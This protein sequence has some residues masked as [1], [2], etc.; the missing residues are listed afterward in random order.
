MSNKTNWIIVIIALLVLAL[1]LSKTLQK[2]EASQLPENE[3]QEEMN[4]DNE[5]A[6]QDKQ[7]DE[8][9]ESNEDE[10]KNQEEV[11]SQN[12]EVELPSEPSFKVSSGEDVSPR[13]ILGYLVPKYPSLGETQNV[14]IKIKDQAG[15]ESVKM[16]IK[17]QDEEE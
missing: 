15:I 17:K 14:K 7:E 16:T 3:K 6:S 1:F 9:K 2:E 4:M 12:K 10:A 8:N 11:Q 5:E 13:F